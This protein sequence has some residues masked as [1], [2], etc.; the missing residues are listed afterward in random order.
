MAKKTYYVLDTNTLL[1]D[2]S[3]ILDYKTNNLILPYQVIKEL[4]NNKTN[5]KESG[6]HARQSI[7]L[8]KE[9]IE[10]SPNKKKAKISPQHGF[11]ILQ[12][13]I[14]DNLSGELDL[15]KPDDKILNV[16]LFFKKKNKKVVLLSNDF[17]LQ[18]KAM[19]LGID[20]EDTVSQ[21]KTLDYSLQTTKTHTISEE[22]M[23]LLFVK[24]QIHQETKYDLFPNDFVIFKTKTNKSALVRHRESGIFQLIKEYNKKS[25]KKYDFDNFSVDWAVPLNKE[26]NFSM[27][28]LLDKNVPVVT[29]VGKS[30]CGK[31]LLALS[32]ALYQTLVTEQYNKVIVSRPIQPMGNDIGYLPGNMQEKLSPW[33][34]PIKDNLE[35]LFGD[36]SIF[37][38]Y[39][40]EGIIEV[41]APTYI[42]GRSLANSII[43]IDESQN[44]HPHEIKTILTRVG[45]GS[46]IIFTG[47]I[48]QIDNHKINKRTNGLTY[49]V[50]KFKEQKLSG[51]V[52]LIKGHR[53]EVASL[54]AELL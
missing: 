49:L 7:R 34:S 51:H 35:F 5:K 54:A 44:L 45:K 3:C 32:T 43:I 29:L 47:D 16:C 4:D 42:R 48:D 11:L 37:E 6:Y 9:I 2:S 15:N 24:K 46:K 40:V 36:K 20:Y 52:H 23:D 39:I 41:E 14:L 17:N 50:E 53:S 8:I 13:D 18:L 38:E 12:E 19:F 31:T 1:N 27:N 10:K 21:E 28:L 22:D 26:Q 33:V 30:G 25:F